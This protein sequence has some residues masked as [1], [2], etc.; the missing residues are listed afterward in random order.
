MYRIIT[1]LLL[2]VTLF[3][4]RSSKEFV[5]ETSKEVR[6]DTSAYK[7]KVKLDTLKVPRQTANLA[8]PFN[9]LRDSLWNEFEKSNGRAK[10]KI[11]LLH[12]TLYAEAVCDSL[13]KVIATKEKELYHYQQQ[14]SEQQTTS[15]QVIIQLPLWLRLILIGG[16]VLLVIL[17]V[18]QILKLFNPTS[19]A[20]KLQKVT[21]E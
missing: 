17:A 6:K 9:V 12:D 15:K 11:Q 16:L 5:K 18:I 1:G 21:Q 4:C 10:V 8:I 13:E 2:C 7:E 19:W 3:S 20:R 14:L